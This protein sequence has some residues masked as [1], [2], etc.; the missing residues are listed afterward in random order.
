MDCTLNE[1][2]LILKSNDQVHLV[3]SA[4]GL[5]YIVF[6]YLFLSEFYIV[7]IPL[8]ALFFRLFSSFLD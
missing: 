4:F 8:F 6:I 3:D 7:F 2:S 1:C 5:F